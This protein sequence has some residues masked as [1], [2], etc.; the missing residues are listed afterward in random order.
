MGLGYVCQLWPASGW[1]APPAPALLSMLPDTGAFP[2]S[3]VA[4]PGWAAAPG[5]ARDMPKVRTMAAA[6]VATRNHGVR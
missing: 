1:L 3:L 4:G 2:A 5:A 6:R